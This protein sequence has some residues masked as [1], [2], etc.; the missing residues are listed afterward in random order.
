MN[1]RWTAVVGALLLAS[2]CG[3]DDG[4]G[5]ASGGSGGSGGASG[6]GGTG[7]AAGAGG[8]GGAAG[9]TGGAGGETLLVSAL[10]DCATASTSCLT[11]D[12]GAPAHTISADLFGDGIEWS[13]RGLDVLAPDPSGQTPG[14]LRSDVMQA[15]GQVG[16]SLMRYPGGT[17][18]D[19]FHWNEAI[20]PVGSRKPQS[21]LTF[22]A[23]QNQLVKEPP[24]FGPDEFDDFS[25]QLGAGIL[26]TVNVMTGTADEA[27]GWVSYWKDKGVS[28][29][30]IEIG[31]EAYL[32]LVNDQVM[33]ALTPA[34]YAQRFDAF[35]AAIRAV[36][37]TIPL[38]AIGTMETS[39]WCHPNCAGPAPWNQVVLQSIQQKIDFFA[40]HNA[41]A[42]GASSDDADTFAAM[43]GYPDF[44][45]FDDGLIE[46]DIDLFAKTENQ[47][48]PLAKTEFASFFVPSAGADLG[49]IKTIVGRNKSW[50]SALY[51]GLVVQTLVANPRITMANHINPLHYLWQAP[52]SVAFPDTSTYPA[53]YQPNPTLSSWGSVFQAYRE[54]GGQRF[55]PV[56]TSNVPTTSTKAIGVMPARTDIPLLDAVGALDAATTP[57]KG[58]LFVA[59]RSLDQD[60]DVAIVLENVPQAAALLQAEVLSAT[61]YL[62]QSEAGLPAVATWSPLL[63]GKLPASSEPFGLELKVPKHSLV[64]IRLHD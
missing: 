61:D 17:L 5:A 45:R 36:D 40:V 2:A 33:P 39:S 29:R 1:T 57:T 22:D 60:L 18:S 25:N 54:L 62:A 32:A 49:A 41:Y 16:F 27:A 34:E 26:L 35:A 31:N 24:L 59:N 28:P 63:S 20:G 38:G 10:S 51:S 44:I 11:L 47:K 64:R 56:Q 8:T 14:A 12:L 7:G 50:A 4:P 6:S 43:L 23:S 30:A 42:P 21:T 37:P 48:I 58:W 46:G 15:L 53:S 19:A 52:V 55:V 3:G 13:A 9:A